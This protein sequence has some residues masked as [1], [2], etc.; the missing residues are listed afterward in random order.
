MLKVNLL[1]VISLF[2]MYYIYGRVWAIPTYRVYL[3]YDYL[4]PKVYLF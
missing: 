2:V 1:Q 3:L 4:P